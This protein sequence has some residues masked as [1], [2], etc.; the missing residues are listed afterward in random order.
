MI[1]HVYSKISPDTIRDAISAVLADVKG[2]SKRKFAQTIELQ[3]GF[4]NYD[5]KEKRFNASVVLP[6]VPRE[7]FSVCVLGT[8][9]DVEA[10]KAAGV[11]GLTQ[12]DLKAFNKDKKKVKVLANS[13]HAF[14]ASSSLIRLIPRLLGPGLSK[15]GKFPAVLNNNDNVADKIQ[16]ARKTVK[17]NM[18]SK[19][20]A[21]FAVAVA[22]VNMTEEQILTNI[23]VAIN[24][25]VS[26]LPKNWQQVKR[27]YLHPTMGKS[28]KIYG[29]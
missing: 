7:K 20:S 6:H 5:V 8:E 16:E 28:V 14:L 19:R 22:N 4:K 2:P 26:L 9:A 13:H 12:D 27:V 3:F 1:F 29:M 18:K 17:M 24:F 11:D 10:A 21:C 15:A 23:T 25:L